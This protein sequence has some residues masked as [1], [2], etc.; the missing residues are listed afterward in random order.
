MTFRAFVWSKSANVLHVVL[1]WIEEH[2][3]VP[4]LA[5]FHFFSNKNRTQK[6]CRHYLFLCETK[7]IDYKFFVLQNHWSRTLKCDVNK[8]SVLI[9]YHRKHLLPWHSWLSRLIGPLLQY[10]FQ[11]C[12]MCPSTLCFFLF[13]LSAMLAFFFWQLDLKFGEKWLKIM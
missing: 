1:D 12:S 9:I 3:P 8:N 13:L 6:M 11:V 10:H 5:S 2:C 7:E 4:F